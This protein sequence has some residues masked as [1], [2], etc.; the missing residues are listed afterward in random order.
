[1]RW[2]APRAYECEHY[3][4]DLE[5]ARSLRHSGTC[6]WIG[7]KEVFKSWSF[8]TFGS[9]HSLLWIHAIP[10]AGKTVL[11]SYLVDHSC[12]RLP[13]SSKVGL[14]M[15]FFF[16][17]AD[18]DKNTP[19]A[20][21]RALLHQMLRSPEMAGKGEFIQDIENHMKNSGQRRAISF[22]PLWSL[23]CKHC[24]NLPNAV[25]ILDAL[26]ECE[27]VHAL[28]PGLCRLA[29]EGQVR[30]IL[31]SRREAA[32]FDPLQGVADLAMG[33]EDVQDDITA[34]LEYSVSQSPVLSNPRVRSRIIRI[35]NNRSKGM[36]LWVALMLKEL[37][38]KGT[39]LEIEAI[40]SAPLPKDL[41]GV[42]ERILTRLNSDLKPSQK[43]FCRKIL[44]W[45]TLA[46]RPL[47]LEEVNEALK[48]EYASEAGDSLFV[49]NLLV[50][51]RELQLVCGSLVAVRDRSIQLVHLSTREFL[52]KPIGWDRSLEDFQV[53][54]SEESAYVATVCVLYISDWGL[55]GKLS[56]GDLHVQSLKA[57][58]PFLDYA[59]FNWVIHLAESRSEVILAT[60]S[61]LEPFL[62]SR[63]S[64]RWIEACF[65]LRNGSNN[66]LNMDIQLLVDRLSSE[67]PSD[68]TVVASESQSLLE[69]WGLSYQ[70]LILN[71]GLALEHRPSDVHAIDPSQ[72][73]LPP[74]RGLLVKFQ[75]G[76]PYDR[77]FILD[78]EALSR[79][80]SEIPR[81]RSLQRHT[82]DDE[83]YAFVHLSRRHGAFLTLDREAGNTP[84]LHI[85]EAATGKRLHP[86]IDNEFGE[87]SDF[88]S[89]QGAAMNVDE[90]FVGIVYRWTGGHNSDISQTTGIYTAIWRLLQ[91]I[92]FNGQSSSPWAYK[93]MSSYTKDFSGICSSR[94]ITF[95]GNDIV[96][97]PHGRVDLVTGLAE[98][99]DLGT[100][101]YSPVPNPWN[102]TF[103]DDG[104]AMV[105]FTDDLR[106]LEYKSPPGGFETVKRFEDRGTEIMG[107]LSSGGRFLTWRQ[108]R[109][110][111]H[112][113]DKWVHGVRVY[114]RLLQ[115]TTELESPLDAVCGADFLFSADESI[116]I[117]IFYVYSDLGS[118]N[119]QIILWKLSGSH[120]I[121]Q[122]NKKV[123]GWLSGYFFDEKLQHLYIFSPERIWSR[124]EIGMSTLDE[125]DL[126][127]EGG[128]PS[129]FECQTSEDGTQM[130]IFQEDCAEDLLMIIDL[131]NFKC[132][133]KRAFVEKIFGQYEEAPALIKFSPGLELVFV[134][135]RIF[136]VKS[137]NLLPM[138]L[139]TPRL[140]KANAESTAQGAWRCA[141]S[142]T[143]KYIALGLGQTSSTQFPTELHVFSINMEKW[144]CTKFF[145]LDLSSYGRFTFGF[146]PQRAEIAIDCWPRTLTEVS[147]S[148]FTA[149]EE[150]EIR[151]VDLLTE[152]V[153]HCRSSRAITEGRHMYQSS[154]PVTYSTDGTQVF[155]ISRNAETTTWAVPGR[156]KLLPPCLPKVLGPIAITDTD[157]LPLTSLSKAA[158][159]TIADFP[160]KKRYQNSGVKDSPRLTVVPTYLNRSE[161]V[162]L[163]GD[164]TES[165]IRVLFLR[166]CNLPEM[167]YLRITLK[168]YLE[169]LEEYSV[170]QD[171]EDKAG[172][173]RMDALNHYSDDDS[174]S[175]SD[176]EDPI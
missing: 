97:C 151:F 130:V 20:V 163:L 123:K 45:I 49:E 143:C 68:T 78:E 24:I 146:H 88:L 32:L 43:T 61:K 98:E 117:G 13:T 172:M 70:R 147:E 137:S 47:H 92:D 11:A 118:K 52:L 129:R 25:I 157:P 96:Y 107:T 34:F 84:R 85:Q 152:P 127:L 54:V 111:L 113:P 122:A 144:S 154:S 5:L 55:L 39:I 73:F 131:E 164:R 91:T 12:T 50:S 132:V 89:I 168:E 3:D 160:I 69:Y 63:Q 51:K 9:D 41:Y 87:E 162:F 110:S 82:S 74:N 62:T 108:L 36:F 175:S 173:A 161:T 93:I 28:I 40:L 66:Q 33:P 166:P 58:K 10:G 19:L 148:A 176:H 14:V 142:A 150:V 75:D 119:S 165:K 135:Y 23:F 139:P 22:R 101:P 48:V 72:I 94:P 60:E 90:T 17:N 46:K 4:D 141:F 77:H 174:L 95:V 59:C 133:Y 106:T 21:T 134:G 104:Q 158:W 27:Q 136:S 2:L 64:F 7:R 26:D 1:M 124:L 44:R 153:S 121:L 115:T 37:E 81:Y 145:F 170:K 35:L 65:T 76:T 169:R 109:F 126:P 31:T 83:D 15:Y 156:S 57:R 103:S 56:N 71:Y 102:I 80:S 112:A 140:H 155:I 38:S 30:I 116:M 99:F 42:Y 67:A 100:N 29:R 53:K 86:V 18:S 171:E 159:Q 120:F 114:D 138:I 149:T 6:Q 8:S 125:I 128:S 16:K 79:H 105:R 167:K